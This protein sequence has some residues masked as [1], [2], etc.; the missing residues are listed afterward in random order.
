[1]KLHLFHPFSPMQVVIATVAFVLASPGWQQVTAQPY[2]EVYGMPNDVLSEEPPCCP[3][4]WEHRSS[5]FGESL[6]LHPT[7]V[8]MAHAQQQNGLGGAGT[9]PF[10]RIGTLDLH[11][12]SAFR[13]GFNW[14]LDSC[15]S[16]A[17]SYT[18]LDTD[19][20]DEVVPPAI[21]AGAVGSLVHHPGTLLTASVGPVRATYAIDFEL[22]EVDYRRLWFGSDSG[23]V[24]YFLGA[25]YGRLGQQFRQQGVFGGALGGAID[26]TTE[27]DFDGG[28]LVIGLDFERRFGWHGFSMYGRTSAAALVGDFRSD[29]SMLNR[30]TS[31]QLALARWEDSRCVPMLDCELGVAWTSWGGH[32]R[33]SAGYTAMFWFNAVTTPEFVRAVQDNDYADVGDT[34]S[35]DGL[36]GRAEYLW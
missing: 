16:F 7:G 29:Y 15:S 27:I 21:P 34:I 2:D 14:A 30:T 20:I 8:D 25:R 5:V 4:P 26:T 11:H 13:S 12:E 18:K 9:V 36:I 24:N 23:W 19:A 35:F 1:M 31:V 3:S 28:G 33:I 10:G 17:A 22:A 32:L 6:Y